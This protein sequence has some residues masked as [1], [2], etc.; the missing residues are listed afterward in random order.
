MQ[1]EHRELWSKILAFDIDGGPATLTFARR[2]ARENGWTYTYA[3]RVIEE[4][5]KFVFLCMVAGA[6][7]HA[8]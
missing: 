6:Q 4:Y 3:E 5:R 7:V 2:L 8:F 1:Y